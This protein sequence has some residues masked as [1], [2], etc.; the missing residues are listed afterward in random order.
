MLNTISL[1]RAYIHQYLLQKP[2]CIVMLPWSKKLSAIL[3]GVLLVYF[4][5]V[6]IY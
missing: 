4:Y 2:Y 1:L 5:E 3:L 6:A